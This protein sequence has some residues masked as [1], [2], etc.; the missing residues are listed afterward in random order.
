MK[1][2]KFKAWLKEYWKPIVVSAA[3]TVVMR[4][5]LGL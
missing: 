3:T 5:I 2:P 4:L 1:H